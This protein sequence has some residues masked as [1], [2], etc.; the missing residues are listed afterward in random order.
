[1]SS[2]LH[3]AHQDHASE[4]RAALQA[5]EDRRAAQVG[6][7]F[8]PSELL[9]L[10]TEQWPDMPLVAATIALCTQEW[11]ESELYTHFLGYAER[12][13][14]PYAG[15]GTLQHPTLGE[16]LVDLVF[17][18]RVEGGV[19]VVGIE[20]M[21]RVFAQRDAD[22]RVEV[23]WPPGFGQEGPAE[24]AE[25]PSKQP[26]PQLRVVHVAPARTG[27]S[28]ASSAPAADRDQTR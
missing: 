4:L 9:R 20:Y 25:P 23:L 13:A 10:A 22:E 14:L 6:Q 16:L 5:I 17:D 28:S 15:G 1:M 19:R 27:G 8:E 18:V 11:P 7:P 3:H 2:E 12:N 26:G 24:E 21:D